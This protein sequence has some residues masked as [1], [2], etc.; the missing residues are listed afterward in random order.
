MEASTGLE[1]L[2]SLCVC[3]CSVALYLF[4]EAWRRCDLEKGIESKV[5]GC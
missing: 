2:L 4:L 1:D 5:V 3:L